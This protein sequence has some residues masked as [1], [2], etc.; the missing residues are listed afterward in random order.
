[1]NIRIARVFNVW[2]K[3]VDSQKELRLREFSG[4]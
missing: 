1:M 4:S 2:D 3:P